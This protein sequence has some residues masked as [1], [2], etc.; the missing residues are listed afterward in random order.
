MDETGLPNEPKKCKVISDKGQKTLLIVPNSGQ[1]N[2]TV[3]GACSVSAIKLPPINNT[4][5][6]KKI[7]FSC[8]DFEN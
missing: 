1:E 3:V 4:G 2:T 5:Q 7:F 6:Q 8:M